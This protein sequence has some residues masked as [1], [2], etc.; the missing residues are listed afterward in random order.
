VLALL[1][2]GKAPRFQHDKTAVFDWQYTT[3][4][5]AAGRTPFIVGTLAGEVVAVNGLQ[6]VHARVGGAPVQACWSLD[7]CVS[8]RHR[9]RGLGRALLERVTASAPLMLG[10]GIS[11]MSDPLFEALQWQLDTTMATLY[12]HTGE[13][14]VGGAAKNLFSRGARAWHRRPG[15]CA[16]RVQVEAAPPPAELTRLWQQVLPHYPNAV[17]RDGAYLGWRY[18]DAPLRHYRWV[19]ARRD[20]VLRALFITRHHAGESVLADYVGPLDDPALLRALIDLACSDLAAAGT[21]RIRCETNQ[22]ALLTA[23]MAQ[24]FR[25]GRHATRFRLHAR[26]GT[27]WQ[28]TAPW[29]VM[30][31]DSDNDLLIG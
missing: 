19:T 27:A 17:E 25:Q 21:C 2:S 1:G 16:A 9:G 3:H 24:G 11:D 14:G 29:F 31:A 22:P 5:L 26:P 20:G 12:F 4:P 13:A 6:H 10:F 23:L 8:S 28:P 18:R 30:T 7:T 15:P